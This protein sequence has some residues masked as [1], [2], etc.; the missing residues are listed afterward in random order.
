MNNNEKNNIK[1]VLTFGIFELKHLENPTLEAEVLLMNVLGKDRVFFRTHPE[2]EL[3][4]EDIV[5]Y[6]FFIQQRSQHIPVAYIIG[7]KKWAGLN[8]KVNKDVL[9][10]R[11]ETEILVQNI[12]ESVLVTPPKFP[13]M[14]GTLNSLRILDIGTGSG[15]ISIYLAKKLPNSTITCLDIS[16]K[17]LT[18]AQQNFEAQNIKATLVASDLLEK[19]PKNS[20]FDIIVAN[21]PYVP[22]NLKVTKD[23]SYEPSNAIF[24]GDDGLGHIR[25]LNVQIQEKNIK[26]HALWLEFLPLQKKEIEKIFNNYKVEFCT[27]SGDDVFFIRIIG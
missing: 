16:K 19:I 2:Y 18:V 5:L 12:L 25:R 26:F 24:S 22:E 20:H 6:E 4:K 21:L 27:D 13:S 9:I 8:I 15:C 11:D 3:K 23:L 1:S 7:Y 17:A 10:P 14:R